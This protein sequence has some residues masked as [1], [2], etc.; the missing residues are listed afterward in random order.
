MTDPDP[1]TEGK[2]PNSDV[3]QSKRFP[4][5]SAAGQHLPGGDRYRGLL[6]NAPGMNLRKEMTTSA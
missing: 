3:A 5:P 2:L 1:K 6:G 4:E